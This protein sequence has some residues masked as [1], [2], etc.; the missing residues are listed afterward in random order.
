MGCGFGQRRGGHLPA[1]LTSFVGRTGELALVREALRR[2]RLVTLAG[3]AGV[4]KSRTALRA[5]TSLAGSFEDGVRLVEL[6]AL[7]DP[8]LIPATLASALD[9]PEQS[10]MTVLD[11]VVDGGGGTLGTVGADG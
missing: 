4:G 7:H 5:A 9:L 8:E 10:G 6:S 1:E 11:A 2:A 3:P